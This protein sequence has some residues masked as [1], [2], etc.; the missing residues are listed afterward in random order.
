MVLCI[1][2]LT[3]RYAKGATTVNDNVNDDYD[4]NDKDWIK[5]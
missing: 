1:Y 5:R 2:I 3:Y 4:T